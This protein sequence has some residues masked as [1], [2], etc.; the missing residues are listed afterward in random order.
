MMF[1]KKPT[2]PV[3]RTLLTSGM[4]DALLHSRQMNGAVVHT[5]QLEIAYKPHWSWQMPPP[6]PVIKK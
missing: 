2:W 1:S 6:P 5:P 4:L 3:E